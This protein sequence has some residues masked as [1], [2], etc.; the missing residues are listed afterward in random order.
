MPSYSKMDITWQEFGAGWVASNIPS[1]TDQYRQLY[2]TTLSNPVPFYFGALPVFGY[3][4][5]D[6]AQGT[7]YNYHR[8]SIYPRYD[9]TTV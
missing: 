8:I 3:Y 7:S 6:I 2:E 1:N 9:E 5:R 4:G